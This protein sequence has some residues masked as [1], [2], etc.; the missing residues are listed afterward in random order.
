VSMEE[1]RIIS[2]KKVARA[3]A[4][5]SLAP[6]VLLACTKLWLEAELSKSMPG[7]DFH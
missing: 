5:G 3:G 4:I 2:L 6:S 7:C 1:E